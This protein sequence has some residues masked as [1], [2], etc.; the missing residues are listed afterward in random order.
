MRSAKWATLLITKGGWLSNPTASGARVL[1]TSRLFHQ[2]SPHLLT[3]AACQRCTTFFTQHIFVGRSFHKGAMHWQAGKTGGSL[4]HASQQ[5]SPAT[6]RFRPA[7]QTALTKASATS[8]QRLRPAPEI[9]PLTAPQQGASEPTWRKA[10]AE[11]GQT[12]NGLPRWAIR[13][14]YAGSQRCARFSRSGP[15]TTLSG[16]MRRRERL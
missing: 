7:R 9:Q 8:A 11:R 3:A 5:V 10:A 13:C 1:R 2:E 4:P 12:K 14:R 16:F 6:L 15:Q